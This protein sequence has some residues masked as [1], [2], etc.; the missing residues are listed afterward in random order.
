MPETKDVKRKIV[1]ELLPDGTFDIQFKTEAAQQ[2]T[3]KEFNLIT[4]ALHVEFGK[5]TRLMSLQR[6]SAL[7]KEKN[8]AGQ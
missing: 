7:E 5:Y 1:I 8:N 6:R 2:F 3:R 4:R